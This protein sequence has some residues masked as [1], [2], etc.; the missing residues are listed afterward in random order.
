MAL[1]SVPL[2]ALTMILCMLT[3]TASFQIPK[4]E[5]LSKKK[6]AFRTN[7]AQTSHN[8]EDI[9]DNC[10]DPSHSWLNKNRRQFVQ[11]LSSIPFILDSQI[12][13]A[14]AV[15]G[16]TLVSPESS[17]LE[18]GLLEIRVLE[19]VLS[20]PP[21]GMESA[22]IFYPRCVAIVFENRLNRRE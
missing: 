21:Y 5:V 4:I 2:L 10:G 12:P 9:D 8:S 16:G 20:P 17:T 22:D 15:S 13:V 19:N 6:V 18:N 14:N 1:R 7:L 3:Y 11:S